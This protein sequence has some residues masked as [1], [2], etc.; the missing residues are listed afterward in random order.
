[1]NQMKAILKITR[2]S[3]LLILFALSFSCK[4][5]HLYEY[6]EAEDYYKQGKFMEAMLSYNKV[7]AGEDEKLAS[8]ALYKVALI[9]YINFK[10]NEKAIDLFSMY[11]KNYSKGL[12]ADEALKAIG[13]IYFKDIHEYNKAISYYQNLIDN[14]VNS[15]LLEETAY[16]LGK[17]Y[18]LLNNYAQA[19]IIFKKLLKDFP[20]G[21]LRAETELEIAGC[22]NVQNKQKEAIELYQSIINKYQDKPAVI[23]MA[24][25]FLASIYE[26][27]DNLNEA[28]KIY[29]T[30]EFTYPN[31]E[32]IK[33]KI[34]KINYRRSMQGR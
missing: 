21:K 15:K 32:I 5:S 27:V 7:I 8:E 26:E 1:M 22:L 25:Y 12:R 3:F 17:S 2:Y 23:V 34:E 33:L 9:Q 4:N 31:P 24:K 14:Y 30:I 11:L 16:Y 18:F 6:D 10:N 28:V 13:D 19:V 29:K 20:E